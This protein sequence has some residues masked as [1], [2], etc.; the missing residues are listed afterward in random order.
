MFKLPE[1]PY[2][3]DALEPHI[4]KNTVEFHYQKHHQG[5][6][7]KLNELTA[8]TE[9]ENQSLEEI[10]KKT[11]NKPEFTDIYNN[12]AQV[13]NHN[14]YWQS[15]T[16]NAV[17]APEEKALKKI[18]SN[19]G[20][21]EELKALMLKKATGQFGSGWVWLVQD[22]HGNLLVYSTSNADN[23][24]IFKHKPLLTVDVW[25]HGYY[26]DYQNRRADYVKAV[27]ENLLNWQ[28]V[29]TI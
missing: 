4:S 25:E 19:F 22:E 16:P 26:L 2:A 5:Y 24:L 6:V 15:L 21:L 28:N 20:S 29:N 7:N 3:L 13:F 10:I 12:A 8:G 27:I 17:K 11:H 9:F 18:E 23:P 1:L 14:F